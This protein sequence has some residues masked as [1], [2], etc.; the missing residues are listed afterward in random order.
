M[1][2]A[3]ENQENQGQTTFFGIVRRVNSSFHRKT[4][5]DPDFALPGTTL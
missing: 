2:N 1:G 5:S 4:W 3:Q